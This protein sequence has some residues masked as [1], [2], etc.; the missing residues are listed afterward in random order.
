MQ[1]EPNGTGASSSSWQ[2]RLPSDPKSWHLACKRHRAPRYPLRPL[3]KWK[4]LAPRGFYLAG[5]HFLSEEA[6]KKEFTTNMIFPNSIKSMNSGS[7][8]GVRSPLFRHLEGVLFF[9]QRGCL[10]YSDAKHEASKT[11]M[12]AFCVH[13]WCQQTGYLKTEPPILKPNKQNRNNTQL[14]IFRRTLIQSPPLWPPVCPE[15]ATKRLLIFSNGQHGGHQKKQK[16]RSP[17]AVTRGNPTPFP[18]S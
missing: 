17:P 2:A 12:V 5:P 4:G 18:A 13:C 16:T 10:K 9:G 7:E 1:G 15:I 8:G 11:A 6:Q 3:Q 14:P